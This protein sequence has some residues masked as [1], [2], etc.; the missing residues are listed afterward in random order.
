MTWDIVIFIIIYVIG[1]R[2][3]TLEIFSFSVTS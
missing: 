1:R 3:V 2:H